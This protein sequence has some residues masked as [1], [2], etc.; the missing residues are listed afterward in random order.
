MKEKN[1]AVTAIGVLSVLIIASA[2]VGISEHFHSKNTSDDMETH[3]SAV[4]FNAAISN[5]EDI[6][7]FKKPS[8]ESEAD[9]NLVEVEAADIIYEVDDRLTEYGFSFDGLEKEIDEIISETQ[10]S[11]GGDWSVYV[12][13]PKTG[14]T[15]S[16]NQEPMQAASVIK[17]FIMGAVYEEY[18]KI[19][20][21]Y[22]Y[23]DI[24]GLLE[25]MITISD[26]EAADLLVTMLGRGD[27]SS[28]RSAVN[29][30][31]KKYGFTKTTMDRMMADDNIYSDNYTTTE[32]CAKFLQML[33]NSEFKH[34]KNML[35]LMRGQ[36]RRNKIPEGVPNSVMVLNKTGELDDVQNDAAIV[37]SKTPYI[38]CV[39]SD[40]VEDYQIPIDAIADISE[41]AYEYIRDNM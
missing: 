38:I 36:T 8:E 34:S 33:Y 2:A 37:F 24:D 14:D 28:G 41:A 27:A 10:K 16:I 35:D 6:E 15:L 7:N 26:N 5:N 9:D 1:L 13:V 39:I 29:D 3:D 18:D 23:D 25:S 21:Y 19:T 20:E 12:T 32:D 11:V 4:E 30:F 31:C 17:L 22:Q 40:G